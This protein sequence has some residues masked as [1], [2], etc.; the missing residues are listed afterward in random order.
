MVIECKGKDFAI[1]NV[2]MYGYFHNKAYI[3]QELVTQVKLANQSSSK[4]TLYRA[5][6][7]ELHSCKQF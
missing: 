4:F 5:T 2:P 7:S 6:I 1:G 3:S